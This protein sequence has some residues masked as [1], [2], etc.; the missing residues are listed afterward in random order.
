MR[1]ESNQIPE[2][3]GRCAFAISTGKEGVEGSE[4]HALI[5]DG[6]KYLF[7][8]P[9]AKFLWRILPRRTAKAESNWNH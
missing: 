6:K 2:F 7:S 3:Q 8:N 9:I 4:N 1:N 5:Q